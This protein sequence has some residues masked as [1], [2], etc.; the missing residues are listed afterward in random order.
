MPDPFRSRCAPARTGS[1]AR[2]VMAPRRGCE[3]AP[4][5]AA[6]LRGPVAEGRRS[7]EAHRPRV[8]SGRPRLADCPHPSRR[9][10]WH[11]GRQRGT[12]PAHRLHQP[13]RALAGVLPPTVVLR[14]GPTQRGRA[15]AA[16]T[17]TSRSPPGD[18]PAWAWR[19]RA[20]SPRD[21]RPNRRRDS[22]GPQGEASRAQG[23]ARSPQPVGREGEREG[24]HARGS[25]PNR[26]VPLP[27]VKGRPLLAAEVHVGAEPMAEVGRP[28]TV[29]LLVQGRQNE[30]GGRGARL[31]DWS[32]RVRGLPGPQ[33][34]PRREAALRWRARGLGGHL[35]RRAARRC[36]GRGP[37][38]SDHRAAGRRGAAAGRG[39]AAEQ[40][41]RPDRTSDGARGTISGAAGGGGAWDVDATEV[42]MWDD[43]LIRP[44]L[45]RGE[46]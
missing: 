2:T 13:R 11:C 20:R 40:P 7:C 12:P 25:K 6:S 41:C 46:S 19:P 27:M 34:S 8:H 38:R 30:A 26:E 18:L 35:W 17:D 10:R 39:C 44:R 43:D 3:L 29:C 14:G 31:G 5:R 16:A 33:Q 9:P 37:L 1:P 36:R 32:G 21:R 23:R 22:A 42:P 24:R 15:P 4:E 45:G 28:T